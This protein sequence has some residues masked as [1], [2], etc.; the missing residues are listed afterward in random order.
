MILC[1]IK[2]K[3]NFISRMDEKYSALSLQQSKIVFVITGDRKE[4]RCHQ[5]TKIMSHGLLVINARRKY[6][7]IADIQQQCYWNGDNEFVRTKVTSL[8]KRTSKEEG[9]CLF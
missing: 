6:T 1:H 9:K 4:G 8:S 2:S 7:F 3:Q 5:L